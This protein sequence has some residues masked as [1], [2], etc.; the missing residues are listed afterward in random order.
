MNALPSCESLALRGLDAV[1]AFRGSLLGRA[2]MVMHDLL[3]DPAA[4]PDQVLRLRQVPPSM[5]A[6]DLNLLWL[7]SDPV[8]VFLNAVAAFDA[9]RKAAESGLSNEY[10][11]ALSYVSR[12]TMV[13]A[14]D[15]LRAA[16]REPPD[17]TTIERV[18][19]VI[20][21]D[22]VPSRYGISHD[23]ATLRSEKLPCSL[24][25]WLEELG[26]TEL[27]AEARRRDRAVRDLVA[28]KTGSTW[29]AVQREARRVAA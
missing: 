3:A 28:G 16:F 15:A 13:Q 7:W 19:R 22:L 10:L 25:L 23:L 5:H 12:R 27:D 20:L 18:S 21:A 14:L 1:G 8:G 4:M 17:P 2:V 11:A 29:S 6:F 26:W 9:P 24:D